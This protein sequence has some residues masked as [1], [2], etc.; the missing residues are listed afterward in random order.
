MPATTGDT[1]EGAEVNGLANGING[2][3]ATPH[4]PQT[5]RN[6]SFSGLALTEYTAEPSPPSL[7]RA[8]RIWKIVPAEYILPN[9]H[10]DVR[11]ASLL[12]SLRP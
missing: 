12:C 10:P 9:G 6:P 8:A 2:T 5:P 3:G 7:E 4:R 11:C 1:N